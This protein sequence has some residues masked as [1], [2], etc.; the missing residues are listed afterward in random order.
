MYYNGEQTGSAT[1]MRGKAASGDSLSLGIMKSLPA[2]K[3]AA[4]GLPFRGMLGD[5]KVYNRVLSEEEIKQQVEESGAEAAAAEGLLTCYDFEEGAG[6]VV[7]DKSGHANDGVVHEATWVEGKHGSALKFS[8]TG[9]YVLSRRGTISPEVKAVSVAMWVYRERPGRHQYIAY[10]RYDRLA[11]YDPYGGGKYRIMS[12]LTGIWSPVTESKEAA[13]LNQW[14]HVAFTW[15]M[16]T[17]DA[18]I[19]YNGVERGTASGKTGKAV[20]GEHLA[21]G[22]ILGTTPEKT[23]VL[24][25]PFQGMLDDVRVYQRILSRQEIKQIMKGY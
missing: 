23:T 11:L 7:H 18:V 16:E 22:G 21:L 8:G 1:G 25:H 3:P 10:E 19:Y 17:G 5:I 12:N 14:T 15:D 24:E 6:K 4:F 2:G 9:Q 13:P 20:T